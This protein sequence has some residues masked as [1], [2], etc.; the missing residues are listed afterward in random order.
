MKDILEKQDK[1]TVHALKRL[2]PGVG[3][4]V[5]CKWKRAKECKNGWVCGFYKSEGKCSAEN[6][7]GTVRFSA[8]Y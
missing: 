8:V 3:I 2:L 1:V 6:V 5:K 4:W 7:G